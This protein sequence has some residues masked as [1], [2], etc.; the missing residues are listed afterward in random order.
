[1]KK[2][3]FS[4]AKEESGKEGGKPTEAPTG[5]KQPTKE[6]KEV[7]TQ[8]T[9]PSGGS[10]GSASPKGSQPTTGTQGTLRTL[11][12]S[13]TA[14]DSSRNLKLHSPTV[15]VLKNRFKSLKDRMR[16]MKQHALRKN[17]PGRSLQV[18]VENFRD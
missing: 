6:A 2:L 10:S 13:S 17:D 4:L 14:R 9:S 8:P 16:L 18:I 1:M 5:G 7:K 15:F 3:C 12:T 11:S